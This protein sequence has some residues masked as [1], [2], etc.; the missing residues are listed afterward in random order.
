MKAFMLNDTI[1]YPEVRQYETLA[2][3]QP[4]NIAYQIN[5]STVAG[6]K[7]RK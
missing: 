1:R 3:N 4:F 6:R 7:K 2:N 5:V